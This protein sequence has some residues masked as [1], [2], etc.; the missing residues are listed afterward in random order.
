MEYLYVIAGLSL[1]SLLFLQSKKMQFFEFTQ[2]YQSVQS[3][4]NWDTSKTKAG[5]F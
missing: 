2:C 4:P 1:T 3:C 5:R